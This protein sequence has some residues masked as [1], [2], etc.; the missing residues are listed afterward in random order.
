MSTDTAI[1]RPARPRPRPRPSSP[2]AVPAHELLARAAAPAATAA[3]AAPAAPVATAA[4]G[5]GRHSHARSRDLDARSGAAQLDR[6]RTVVL[7][8]PVRSV[9][10]WVAAFTLLF[11]ALYRINEAING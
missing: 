10:I 7:S 4:A 2:D 5:S 9:L 3:P 8:D 6:F 11:F 1:N